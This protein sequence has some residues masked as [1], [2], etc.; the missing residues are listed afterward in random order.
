MLILGFVLALVVELG[1]PI[2]L[3]AALR[4]RLG[5]SWRFFLYGAI[6]FTVFQLL[7][8][9]PAVTVLGN[10]VKPGEHGQVFA[11]AWIVALSLTAGLFEEVG[12][13]VGYRWLFKPS[14]RTVDNGL[15]YGV[16]HAGI[17]S[18]ALVGLSVLSTLLTVIAL[19]RVD[20]AQL[21]LPPAQADQLR[22]ILAMS[23]WTPLLGAFERV[24]TLLVHVSLSLLVLRVFLTGRIVWLWLAI[25]YHALFDFVVAGFAVRYLGAVGAEGVLA[26][27][28]ALS[29]GFIV[30]YW[31]ARPD[32]GS[33]LRLA[34]GSQPNG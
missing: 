29:L 13:Y 3:A 4:R 27:F 25:G 5:A 15:M 33:A 17:E 19:Q 10:V 32:D 20:V 14:E 18:I 28:A 8:R 2:V 30:W 16:G 9:I 11:W 22:Q 21:N 7:T 31:R 26:V 34:E 1:L 24:G 23:W 12:R 6:V